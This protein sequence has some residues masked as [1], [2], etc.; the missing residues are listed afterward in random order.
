MKS[1]GLVQV[2]NIKLPNISIIGVSEEIKVQ[3]KRLQK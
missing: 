1:F 2:D 3:E